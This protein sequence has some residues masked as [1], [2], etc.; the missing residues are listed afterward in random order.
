MRGGAV[1]MAPDIHMT[2]LGQR[3]PGKDDFMSSSLVGVL[4]TI[5]LSRRRILQQ[6]TLHGGSL[7]RLRLPPK[8]GLH[9]F[10]VIF[11]FAFR[12]PV[13]D[14]LLRCLPGEP[15]CLGVSRELCLSHP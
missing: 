7:K 11:S 3:L 6:R 4:R 12:S 15:A 2:D 5:R 10:L 8:P 13:S 1:A 14:D 9:Q